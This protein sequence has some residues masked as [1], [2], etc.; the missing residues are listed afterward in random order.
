MVPITIQVLSV[1]AAVHSL[2]LSN[3][4]VDWFI[5]ENHNQ[6]I[7]EWNRRK[8]WRVQ[9][10]KWTNLGGL[11]VYF[12]GE[13]ASTSRNINYKWIK[14]ELNGSLGNLVFGEP[15]LWVTTCELWSLNGCPS[16]S[17]PLW[18][19]VAVVIFIMIP[20]YLYY[21][22]DYHTWQHSPQ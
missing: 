5:T 20:R 1:A 6:S 3:G 8:K 2:T 13:W 10:I 4:S 15:C 14:L 11:F 7:I 9:P 19:W 18:H 22:R 21:Y 12:G 17:A 16:L